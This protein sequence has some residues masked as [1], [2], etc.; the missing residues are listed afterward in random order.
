MYL[1]EAFAETRLDVLCDAIADIGLAALVSHTAEGLHASHIPFV[2]RRKGDTVTL[3]AHVARANDHWRAIDA[4][5]PT[6]A[7]FQ[8]PHAY[9]SPS[10]Y[11]SKA[12]NAKV[13]PTWAYIA[14]HAH[15]RLEIMDNAG[16]HSQLNALTDRH[17]T[18]RA[19][20]WAVS[21]APDDY[22]NARAR[23]IVGLRL[24]VDQL[25]GKWK[26]NQGKSD[27]DVAGT[28]AGLRAEG[29]DGVAL[30]EALKDRS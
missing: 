23:G 3:E 30:A 2:V 4:S 10:F 28:E 14:I 24:H 21:D 20:P 12:E 25:I 26:I 27:A 9:V 19:V 7:I 18:G 17:E 8:G 16:L 1:P 5:S 6:M 11:P 15:G 13:V 22:I 29:P